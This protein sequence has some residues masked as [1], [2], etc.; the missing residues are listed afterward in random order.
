MRRTT[1][2]SVE[3]DANAIAYINAVIAAGGTLTALER[4]EVNILFLNLKGQGPNNN[5]VDLFAS[6]KAYRIWPR[7]GGIAASHLIDIRLNNGSY[8]GGWTHDANGALSNGT[9]GYFN[10]GVKNQTIGFN[11]GL[12]LSDKTATINPTGFPAKFGFRRYTGN[13]IT[14]GGEGITGPLMR[15]FAF[16]NTLSNIIPNKM[17]GVLRN[18]GNCYLTDSTST[19][20][21]GSAQATVGTPDFLEIYVG[22]SNINGVASSFSPVQDQSFAITSGVTI[23][24]FL[25]IRDILKA[26]NTNIGRY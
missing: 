8:F 3:Y 4:S 1:V 23:Q 18:G 2:F 26:F 6:N 14:F 10:T 17:Y 20:T 21:A 9:N 12:M 19:S 25:L 24:E 13:I 16:S 22:C 15:C 7:I 11:L 5:T